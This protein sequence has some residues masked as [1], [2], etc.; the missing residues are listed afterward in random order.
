M[1]RQLCLHVTNRC[2]FNCSYCFVPKTQEDMPLRVAYQAIRFMREQ[3]KGDDI[4]LSFF[5]GEPLLAYE[6]I[7]KITSY[8]RER[9]IKYFLLVTNG[10]LLDKEKLSFLTR[11]KVDLAISCDGVPRAHDLTRRLKGHKT[12]WGK[13]DKKLDFL[14]SNY[15]AVLGRTTFN[16]SCIG[17][18]FTS[19]TVNSLSASAR[20]L[21]DK[22]KGHKIYLSLVPAMPL[23]KEWKAVIKGE[24]LE[25]I[26]RKEMRGI[27]DLFIERLIKK[28]P[29]N[30]TVNFCF[31]IDRWSDPLRSKIMEE[32]PFCCAG[33]K[34]L[35]V[36]TDGGIFPCY[37]P[38]SL[39][40]KSRRFLAG[41]VYAGIT[42]PKA[43]LSF[44]SFKNKAFS[45]LYWN[46]KVNQNAGKPAEVYSIL[47]KSWVEAVRY[48]RDQVR[49]RGIPV[50]H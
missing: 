14:N 36:S 25:S 49:I 31:L 19:Q 35:F 26:L 7:K 6:A 29:F 27:A 8:A 15:R 23:A 20:Y 32:V 28:S 38:A 21:V 39:P 3:Y 48:I 18:T 33:T 1:L 41:D 37:M 45:C 22:F 9:G 5:G 16:P 10:L 46:Y 2:N 13:V 43:L 40:R 47:Y 44:S 4:V 17:L 42:D 11:N 24:G 34:K 30:F 12:S 50:E